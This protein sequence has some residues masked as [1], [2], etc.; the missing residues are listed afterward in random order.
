MPLSQTAIDSIQ[1]GHAFQLAQ[2]EDPDVAG[3][4]PDTGM[5]DDYLQNIRDWV[6]SNPNAIAAAQAS[7]LFPLAS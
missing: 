7:G 2:F 4:P 1:K 6:S 5:P 3:E